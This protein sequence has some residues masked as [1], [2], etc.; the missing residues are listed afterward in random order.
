VTTRCIDY[1][2]LARPTAPAARSKGILKG[3]LTEERG[4]T[5]AMAINHKCPHEVSPFRATDDGK[6]ALHLESE[7]IQEEDYPGN[8]IIHVNP[9]LILERN[10]KVEMLLAPS[11]YA[12]Y[13]SLQSPPSGFQYAFHFK[14]TPRSISSSFP[15]PDRREWLDFC[16]CHYFFC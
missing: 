9:R 7:P 13:G 15:F 14:S 6:L 8:G 3:C 2:R 1:I 5:I 4:T 16:L 12:S 11:I 10:R